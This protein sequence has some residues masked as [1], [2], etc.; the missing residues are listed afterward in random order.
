MNDFDVVTGPSPSS[1]A[2]KIAP[3][4]PARDR[5]N[6]EGE[7]GAAAPPQFPETARE[8]STPPPDTPGNR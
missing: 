2:V 1:V 3:A 6:D 5:R 4:V 8:A 7:R